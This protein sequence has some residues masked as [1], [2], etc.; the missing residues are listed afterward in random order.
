MKAIYT[1]SYRLYSVTKKVARKRVLLP[2]LGHYFKITSIYRL[3]LICLVPIYYTKTCSFFI[4][5]DQTSSFSIKISTIFF[6][7]FMLYTVIVR[8]SID[9]QGPDVF[10][11]TQIDLASSAGLSMG[12]SLRMGFEPTTRFLG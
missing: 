9:L 7:N 10:Y 8:Y 12:F 4:F 5:Y 6:G 2:S 3:T 1:S 11:L